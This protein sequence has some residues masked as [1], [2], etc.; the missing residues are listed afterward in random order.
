[1]Q[2]P[3]FEYVFDPLCG[4]CYASAPALAALA[5]AWPDRLEMMPSGLFSDSGARDL[6]PDWASYAWTNDQRIAAMTG[7]AF[8]QRYHRD[9]LLGNGVRF[10]SGPMNRALTLVRERAPFQEPQVLHRLQ[11]AR[12]VH[13]QDTGAAHV[14]AGLTAQVLADAGCR[15]D[16]ADLERR[17]D[18][19][20]AL[21]QWTQARTLAARSL[22]SRLGIR[23][24]PQLLLRIG[25]DVRVV[26]SS[27][28]YH[29]GAHLLDALKSLA[30][31]ALPPPQNIRTRTPS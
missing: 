30:G 17:L 19:D 16:A 1:M 4:W 22:M 9:V 28:L 7:Q 18:S 29:G 31:N 8:S 25:G 21:A 23:G 6:T 20:P 12:Y 27:A 24:V 13:G 11:V 3:R 14:V 26:P 15:I 5:Q 10:D 2:D